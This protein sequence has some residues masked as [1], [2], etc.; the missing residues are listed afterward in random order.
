MFRLAPR[1]VQLKDNQQLTAYG[2]LSTELA[3]D[4]LSYVHW[5]RWQ[6]A[7]ITITTIFDGAS[8]SSIMEILM[9]NHLKSYWIHRKLLLPSPKNNPKIPSADRGVGGFLL[10]LVPHPDAAGWSFRGAK[11]NGF[12]PFL[13]VGRFFLDRWKMSGRG[14]ELQIIGVCWNLRKLGDR[15][16]LF[17]ELVVS[18]DFFLGRCNC[19]GS[20]VDAIWYSTCCDARLP[21]TGCRNFQKP[22]S[23]LFKGSGQQN[24][25]LEHVGSNFWKSFLI[26]NLCLIHQT[27]WNT[28]C[29]S[30]WILALNWHRYIKIHLRKKRL[31]IINDDTGYMCNTHDTP[32]TPCRKRR[33]SHPR[34]ISWRE[35]SLVHTTRWASQEWS[36]ECAERMA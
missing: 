11:S 25:G 27:K 13:G 24:L 19:C 31:I 35:G 26:I 28:R 4:L 34:W 32:G 15:L 3:D 22:A 6:L 1:S 9:K 20:N 18:C 2:L 8:T 21:A 36:R 33:W 5:L 7:V 14:F 10:F 30:M 29:K 12:Q 17:G 16:F 23:Q